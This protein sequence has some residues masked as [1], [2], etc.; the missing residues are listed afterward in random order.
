MANSNNLLNFSYI[1]HLPFDVQNH[2]GSATSKHPFFGPSNTASQ[3][4]STSDIQVTAQFTSIIFSSHKKLISCPFNSAFLQRMRKTNPQRLC[5]TDKYMCKTLAWVSAR[6]CFPIQFQLAQLGFIH[7]NTD[8]LFTIQPYH[9]LLPVA[10]RLGY[11]N[12][13]F[14]VFL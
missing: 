8:L 10:Q 1:C 6:H 3:V 9:L 12:N 4:T 14:I 2:P 13:G 5:V 11:C 7:K